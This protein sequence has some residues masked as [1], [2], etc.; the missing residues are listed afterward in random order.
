M[1]YVAHVNRNEKTGVCCEHDLREH[2]QGVGKIAGNFAEAF[3][4]E[5]WARLA[6]MWHDLG[7]FLPGWQAYIRRR[8]GCDA[9]A[10]IEGYGSRPN[11]STVGAILA[12][13]RFRT[14]PKD[15]QKIARILAYIIA[16]HHAGLPDWNPDLAGGDLVNRLYQNPIESVL[17]LREFNQIKVIDETNDYITA[18]LPK[19]A[20]LGIKSPEDMERNRE[21]FHLWI[22]M[23]FSCLVDA[24]F[25]DTEKFM[26]PENY[27]K[28]G[29]YPSLKELVE[30]FNPYMEQKQKN[31]DP[32]AINK[33]RTDV[34]NCCRVKA[35]LK[36][37][38]FSLC[39]PTGGGKTLSS[40]AFALKH[41][42]KYGKQ[43]I[44][45]A[46]PYTSIIEQTAAVYKQVFGEEAVLEHHSNID[47][48]K[49]D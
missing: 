15:I 47:P 9:D 18:A 23:L 33:A 6:G 35:K 7:K 27:K 17:D 37:G 2:L 42:F 26:T 46:I 14:Y 45:M 11:H 10:H 22:R 19:S 3:G 25:L 34:L 1:R 38:F 32:T 21:H 29:V 31:A 13:E 48:D 41:A 20:P 5:D 36:P 8:T 28:R 40:M 16:G 43:R 24:D 12:I 49:E 39:V 4:N 44:I 30:R